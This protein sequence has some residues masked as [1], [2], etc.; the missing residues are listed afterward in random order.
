MQNTPQGIESPSDPWSQWLLHRRHGGDPDLER[1]IRG[2]V[3]GIRDHVLDGAKL[4]PGMVLV[5]VGAGDGLIPFGAFERAGSSLQAIFTDVSAPLLARAEQRAV[6]LGLRDRCVFMQTPAE[7]LEGI[8]NES[9]DVLTSRAVLAYVADKMKALRQFHRV[10][11]PGGRISI[12][13]PINRDAA[14]QLAAVTNYL[15]SQPNDAQTAPARLYQRWRAAQ[16]PSTKEEIMSN[17]LTNFTERDLFNFFRLAGFTEVHLE[18]HIDERKSS[19]AS[20]E[21]YMNIAPLPNTRTMREILVSDFSP[22]EQSLLEGKLRPL[23]ES[24]LFS[25]RDTIAYLT[26]IK[27]G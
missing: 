15:T 13:E 27:P 12:G 9:A 10:L 17:P 25:E 3:E 20:W 2:L 22:E 16:F 18:L 19:I 26:A 11:K 5:D 1:V 24:N 7:E 23:F 14:M 4:K 21:T 6:E 8:A